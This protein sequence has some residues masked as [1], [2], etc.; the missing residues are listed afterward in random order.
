M[1]VTCGSLHED[2]N[3]TNNLG[4]FTTLPCA[5]AFEKNSVAHELRSPLVHCGTLVLEWFPDGIHAFLLLVPPCFSLTG[6]RLLSDWLLVDTRR[7]CFQLRTVVPLGMK[8]P[9]GLMSTSIL[10][11]NQRL[12]AVFTPG[13]FKIGGDIIHP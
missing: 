9:F 12:M 1:L 5:T 13:G 4:Y 6:I 3:T 2:A 11:R 7:K 10:L 8:L